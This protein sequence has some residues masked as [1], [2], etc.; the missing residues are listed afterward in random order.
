MTHREPM[1]A[2][3]SGR[4][5][6]NGI[7]MADAFLAGAINVHMLDRRP[8]MTEAVREVLAILVKFF[9]KAHLVSE[10]RKKMNTHFTFNPTLRIKHNV[11]VRAAFIL[12]TRALHCPALGQLRRCAI[13]LDDLNENVRMRSQNR[14]RRT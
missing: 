1:L 12:V 4:R 11:D 2:P 13:G 10:A 3:A 9:L 6:M 5:R 7:A 8:Y 14:D